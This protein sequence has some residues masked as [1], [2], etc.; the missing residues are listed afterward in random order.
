M[1]N[2]KRGIFFACAQN[3]TKTC[4]K[5]VSTKLMFQLDIFNQEF[6]RQKCFIFFRFFAFLQ[7]SLFSH[8]TNGI[9]WKTDLKKTSQYKNILYDSVVNYEKELRLTKRLLSLEENAQ[10]TWKFVEFLLSFEVKLCRFVCCEVDS[11]KHSKLRWQIWRRTQKE[12][13]SF[14]RD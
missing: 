9:G 11:V 6:S 14:V 5:F 13:V 3:Q 12:S 8:Q 2:P 7:I 10:F 1:T 4:T